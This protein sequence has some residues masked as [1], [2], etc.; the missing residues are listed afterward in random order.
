M[1][2]GHEVARIAPE[3]IRCDGDGVVFRSYFPKEMLPKDPTGMWSCETYTVGGQLVGLKKF[4]V[5]TAEGRSTV[6]PAGS[7]SD[8]QR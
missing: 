8:A 1:Y 6:E 5:L 7:G 2:K 4:E 3:R